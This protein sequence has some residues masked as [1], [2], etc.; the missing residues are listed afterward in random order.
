[1]TASASN[2]VG[3]IACCGLKLSTPTTAERL[4]LSPLFTGSLAY[5]RR[6][7]MKWAIL[8]AKLGLVMPQQI[9]APYDLT[10]RGMSAADRFNWGQNVRR[11]LEALWPG[12]SFL[13]LAG[14][15]YRAPLEGLSLDVPMLGL[16]IGRQLAF[17]VADQKR[18]QC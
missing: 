13:V 2:L 1:V 18:F 15:L 6:R 5:V 10:L 9:V 14:S 12:S 8:S 4:Y 11:S 3:L 16:G 7:T 17:L